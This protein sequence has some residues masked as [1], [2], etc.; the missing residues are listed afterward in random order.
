MKSCLFS[1]LDVPW[2]V[3]ND[4]TPQHIPV[5]MGINFG[6]CDGLMSEHALDGP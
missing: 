1:V 2:M 5:D 6:R 3:F 4:L